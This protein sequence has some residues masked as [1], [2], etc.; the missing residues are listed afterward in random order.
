MEEKKMRIC[1]PL[2]T[3]QTVHHLT[4]SILV[5]RPSSFLYTSFIIKVGEKIWN[6]NSTHSIVPTVCLS[7]S[8]NKED[9]HKQH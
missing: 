4:I 7:Q 5:S 9:N 3:T 1:F 8:V 2:S 6:F